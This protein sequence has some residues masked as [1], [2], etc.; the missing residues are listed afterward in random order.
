[1]LCLT[2]VRCFLF[3]ARRVLPSARL[4]TH[5]VADLLKTCEEEGPHVAE[6]L[7]AC[8]T[9][10]GD[11]PGYRKTNQDSYAVHKTFAST[12]G[13]F[14]SVFDGHGPNGHLVSGGGRFTSPW[15]RFTS[16]SF[17]S[18]HVTIVSL[19]DSFSTRPHSP[20]LDPAR[21]RRRVNKSR[22]VSVIRG[23]NREPRA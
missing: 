4:N 2:R 10:A 7:I 6:L 9:R 12:G 17:D 3:L 23:S 21:F 11:E 22:R 8:A 14:F 20:Q 16:P 18:F 19:I 13:S 1:M 15:G 5:T